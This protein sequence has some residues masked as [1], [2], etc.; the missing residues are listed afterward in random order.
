M[1]STARGVWGKLKS[2]DLGLEHLRMLEGCDCVG[3]A[4]LLLVLFSSSLPI[5]TN[6]IPTFSLCFF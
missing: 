1:Q 3:L 5:F 4:V 2:C 6:N